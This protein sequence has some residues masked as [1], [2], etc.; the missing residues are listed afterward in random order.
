MFH[1]IEVSIC[2][3]HASTFQ[4]TPLASAYQEA[5]ALHLGEVVYGMPMCS[6]FKSSTGKPLLLRDNLELSTKK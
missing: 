3:T 5:K 4:K 6:L 1:V 2:I